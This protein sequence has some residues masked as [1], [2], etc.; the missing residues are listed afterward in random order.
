MHSHTNI[1]C[2]KQIVQKGFYKMANNKQNMQCAL[3]VFEK[4]A[5]TTQLK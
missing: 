1:N 2:Y 4:S 5:P 3:N